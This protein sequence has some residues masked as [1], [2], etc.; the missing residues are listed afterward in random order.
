MAKDMETNKKVVSRN[1]TIVLAVLCIVIL[2][3]TVAVIVWQASQITSTNNKV[4]SLNTQVTNLNTQ[5]TNLTKLLNTQIANATALTNLLFAQTTN[6][7]NLVNQ[8]KSLDSQLSSVSS[9]LSGSEQ[10][11]TALLDSLITSASNSPPFAIGAAGTLKYAW[12][13]IL[14]NFQAEYPTIITAPALFEGSSAVATTEN[15]TKQFSIEAAADTTTIPSYLFST[16]ADYEIAFG[17]TQMVII[18]NLASPAGKQL[19]SMWQAAQSLTVNSAAYNQSWQKMF[20]LIATNSTTKVGISDPFTDPSGYQ[21]AGMLRLAGLTFFGNLTYLYNAVYNNPNKYYKAS[22][23][24]TLVTLM[25]TQHIDFI[26]SAYLS[27]A[28]PQT[29]NSSQTQL[30]YITLPTSVNLQLMSMI[31][32]YQKA[33]FSYTELG[34]TESFV[35]N[36]VTYTVTIPKVSTNAAAAT[37]FIKLLF[38]PGSQAILSQNG[39]TPLTPGIYYGTGADIPSILSS[40]V[41]PV[42]ATLASLFP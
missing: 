39:I 23:E 36:P 31:H 42:N 35:I 8:L 5:V 25:Q 3:S 9:Q 11:S 10:N 16:L 24:T 2:V 13:T 19:Y 15:S 37:L 22:T 18:T 12:G 26:T 38:S 7:T 14:S 6:A 28:I 41:T 17:Q 4:N 20:N 34:T 1:L 40:D 30:A 27:N 33:D 32:Y 29:G 21:G